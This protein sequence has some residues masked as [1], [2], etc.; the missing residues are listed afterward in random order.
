MIQQLTFRMTGLDTQSINQRW[1]NRENLKN[2]LREK[3]K[4][5]QQRTEIFSQQ[6]DHVINEQQKMHQLVN[7]IEESQQKVALY[8]FYSEKRYKFS[9]PLRAIKFTCNK[10]YCHTIPISKGTNSSDGNCISQ[11][12]ISIVKEIR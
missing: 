7:K 6:A 11:W 10:I 12:S 5:S 9:F 1:L 2:A 4:N 3:I 8:P